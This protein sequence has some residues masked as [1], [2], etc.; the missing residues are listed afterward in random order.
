MKN[1]DENITNIPIVKKNE[2]NYFAQDD[3]VPPK[4]KGPR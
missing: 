2:E 3:L 1:R 4:K